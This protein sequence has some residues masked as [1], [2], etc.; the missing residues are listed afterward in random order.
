MQPGPGPI[1]FVNQWQSVETVSDDEGRY[2]ACA[3][4]PEQSASL[5][6]TWR[7]RASAV[8]TFTIQPDTIHQ[9]NLRTVGDSV[10]V[11]D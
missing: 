8:A 6:V 1:R 11:R 10:F 7:G 5:W 9:R 4:P 2:L 3:L